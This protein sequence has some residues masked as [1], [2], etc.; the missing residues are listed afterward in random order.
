[1]TLIGPLEGGSSWLPS[2]PRYLRAPKREPRL[3][4]DKNE[5]SKLIR[6]V[7]LVA[8]YVTE[9]QGKV[10]K[11]CTRWWVASRVFPVGWDMVCAS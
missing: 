4:S 11:Y 5:A 2:D 10:A 8:F 1:M 3:G 7:I 9:A 6:K